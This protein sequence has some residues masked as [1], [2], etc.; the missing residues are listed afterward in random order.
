M[1]NKE[2]K[3]YFLHMAT[4]VVFSLKMLPVVDPEFD[5]PYELRNEKHMRLLFAKEFEEQ[6]VKL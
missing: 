1:N 6:F 4:G 3:G 2:R 5:K